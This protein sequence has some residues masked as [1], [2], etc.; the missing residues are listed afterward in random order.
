MMSNMKNTG[1]NR[2]CTDA[3]TEHGDLCLEIDLGTTNSVASIIN[4]KTNDDIVSKIFNIPRAYDV[5]S[6][7]GTV[8]GK[9]P[10]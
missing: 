2:N 3:G 8:Y 9:S 1:R 5:F 6:V 7:A 4:V 10:C